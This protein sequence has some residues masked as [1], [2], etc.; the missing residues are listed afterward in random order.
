MA[1]NDPIL[2]LVLPERRKTL[3]AEPVEGQPQQYRWNVHLQGKDETVFF[4]Y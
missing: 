2:L 3:M 1:R 4:N